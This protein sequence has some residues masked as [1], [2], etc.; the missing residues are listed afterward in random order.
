M[1][2]HDYVDRQVTLPKR[3]TSPTLGPL[4]QC[5]QALRQLILEDSL[6]LRSC[7]RVKVH[8]FKVADYMQL[9]GEEWICFPFISNKKT[10]GVMVIVTEG[11]PRPQL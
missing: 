10:Q 9:V 4:P 6:S 8:L 11:N 5:N 1:R 7:E 2:D 3:V